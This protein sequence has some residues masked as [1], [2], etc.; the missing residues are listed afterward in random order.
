M[1][2][3]IFAVSLLQNQKLPVF[4]L[5]LFQ[6]LISGLFFLMIKFSR[7]RNR[8]PWACVVKVL[9]CPEAFARKALLKKNTDIRHLKTWLMASRH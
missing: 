2:Q 8:K 6:A 5:V 4:H 9:G 3:S 1:T 7:H